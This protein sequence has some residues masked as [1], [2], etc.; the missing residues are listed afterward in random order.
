M[1]SFTQPPLGSVG[2]QPS[3]GLTLLGFGGRALVGL[4]VPAQAAPLP[5]TPPTPAPPPAGTPGTEKTLPEL[6]PPAPFLFPPLK[7]M[8]GPAGHPPQATTCPTNGFFG[9]PPTRRQSTT[10]TI[11]TPAEGKDR[12]D[13][14]ALALTFS[15]KERP[16]STA[17]MKHWLDATGTT[18]VMAAAPFKLVESEVPSFLAGTTRDKFEAGF[19]ARLK[20]AKHP[21]G[22]MAPS[23]LTAGALGPVRFLQFESGPPSPS[24]TK[25]G[26][27]TDLF[28]ALG[29]FNVHS[30]IW[31]QATFLRHEGGV[32]GIGGDDVFE[33]RIL[34]WC[35]QV[36]DVYD[37]NFG[38][39]HVPQTPFPLSDADFATFTSKVKL[40]MAGVTVRRFGHDVNM[41]VIADSLFRDM[42]V[43]G[44][45]RAFL[46]RSE[47]FEP[48]A[49]AMGSFVIKI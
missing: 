32:L 49:N 22:G 11:L 19:T 33:V 10:G 34:K 44:L 14:I 35:V 5:L 9:D 25:G 46:V 4:P 7:S 18:L 13:M 15:V 27:A 2:T 28:T 30:A 47:P 41:V 39:L 42:E 20:D 23:S 36:Y 16:L 40:P 17:N 12:Q 29:S 45:G 8:P 38:K 48:A 6:P 26:T 37:W 43:S 3:V 31:A 24:A 1:T 21:Q